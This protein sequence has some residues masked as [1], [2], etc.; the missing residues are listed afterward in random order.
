MD[1]SGIR[2]AY[3]AIVGATVS[4]VF[5]ADHNRLLES[6]TADSVLKNPAQLKIRSDGFYR[7]LGGGIQ[8]D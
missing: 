4:Q 6:S 8:Y 1:S 5:L 7:T 2:I 3:N